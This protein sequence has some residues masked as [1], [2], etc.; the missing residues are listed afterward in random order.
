LKYGVAAAREQANVVETVSATL[1]VVV[2][3]LDI[4]VGRLLEELMDSLYQ[5]VVT[6]SV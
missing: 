6:T 2:L 5:D 3:M 1:Q 4:M